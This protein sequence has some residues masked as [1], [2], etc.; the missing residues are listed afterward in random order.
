MPG[1]RSLVEL[2]SCSRRA[3]TARSLLPPGVVA[4]LAAQQWPAPA[5]EL[6]CLWPSLQPLYPPPRRLCLLARFVPPSHCPSPAVARM[7]FALL[8]SSCRRSPSWKAYGACRAR[9][10][11]QC[12]PHSHRSACPSTDGRDSDHPRHER[13]QHQPSP[14]ARCS[15]GLPLSSRDPA[16]RRATND[17]EAGDEGEHTQAL[18]HTRIPTA[19]QLKRLYVEYGLIIRW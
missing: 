1:P 8:L 10:T 15:G 5:Q 19:A 9:V 14:A 12:H 13:P 17:A 7:A 3:R 4:P 16:G 6:D 11:S 2:Q 18:A